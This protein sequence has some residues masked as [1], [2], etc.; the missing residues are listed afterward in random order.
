MP[1]A[2]PTVEDIK[3]L[4]Q[5]YPSK[6]AVRIGYDHGLSHRIEAA[7]DFFLMPSRFEPCGLNQMYSLRYGAVPIVRQTGGLDNSVIDP[8]EDEQRANGIKF[9]D[10]SPA[11][12]AKATQKALDLLTNADRHYPVALR[13]F[14]RC[15]RLLALDA[16]LAQ[17]LTGQTP[18]AL[19]RD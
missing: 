1:L 10:Y 19:F 13:Q 6:V 17:V 15:D 3:D 4:A 18:G 9:I 11:A 12:L 16:K 14:Q 2:K 8:R 5:R 7:S